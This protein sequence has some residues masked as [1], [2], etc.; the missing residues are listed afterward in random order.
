M[1]GSAEAAA[2]TCMAAARIAADLEVL[3][4]GLA[5]H[6]LHLVWGVRRAKTGCTFMITYVLVCALVFAFRSGYDYL[7]MLSS[8]LCIKFLAVF[9]QW[10]YMSQVL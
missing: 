10:T 4:L 6:G 1:T 3:N 7:D 2:M 9:R 8:Q 5:A